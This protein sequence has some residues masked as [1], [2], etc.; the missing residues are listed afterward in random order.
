MKKYLLVLFAVAV[1]ASGQE[2]VLN[3]DFENGLNSWT[4]EFNNG[5]GAYEVSV[6]SSYHPDQK[7]AVRVYKYMRSFANLSQD[8]EIPDLGVE[9]SASAKLLATKGETSGH[10]SFAAL[11]VVYISP[12]GGTLGQTMI[13]KHVGDHPPENTAWQHVYRVTSDDWESYRFVLEDELRNNLTGIN[14][15]NVAGIKL[16]LESYGTG[17][18]G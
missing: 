12:R 10:Y 8:V 7:N 14:R 3:G 15:A 11:R 18:S 6:C 9:F 1:L 13:M 17:T 4:I 5:E 16:I 2:L